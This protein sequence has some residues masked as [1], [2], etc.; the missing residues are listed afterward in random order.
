MNMIQQ[1]TTIANIKV[2]LGETTKETIAN[3]MGSLDIIT[4]HDISI[5]TDNEIDQWNCSTNTKTRIKGFRDYTKLFLEDTDALSQIRRE[6]LCPIT[7]VYPNQPILSPC[8]GRIFD[9]TALSQHLR[10]SGEVSGGKCPLCRQFIRTSLLYEIVG[11][12]SL[13]CIIDQCK[14]DN[15]I[16]L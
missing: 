12:A 14:K 3:N 6:M 2:V 8:C 13:K 15:N 1:D 11:N 5:L 7:L 4:V 16:M 9:K 10:N